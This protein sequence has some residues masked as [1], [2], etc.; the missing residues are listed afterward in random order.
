ME[1]L[2]V[3]RILVELLFDDVRHVGAYIILVYFENF[4][5]IFSRFCFLEFIHVDLSIVALFKIKDV[6][7]AS[8]A[9]DALRFQVDFDPVGGRVL[10][11]N[12]F[13]VLTHDKDSFL[14]VVEQPFITLAGQLCFHILE[15]NPRLHHVDGS[16]IKG[17]HDGGH[18][19]L[20][21]QLWKPDFLID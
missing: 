12:F 13:V 19:K 11:E 14:H 8:Q 17:H 5:T 4:E 1:D 20:S 3:W 2:L 6:I 9:H 16:E 18:E 15:S 10:K 7:L 21:N